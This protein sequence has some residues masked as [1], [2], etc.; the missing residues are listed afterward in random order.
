M[1]FLVAIVS[2]G[3]AGFCLFGFLATYEPG[4]ANAMAFRIGYGIL[5]FASCVYAIRTVVSGKAVR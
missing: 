3:V 1:K 2:L 5:G 4:V